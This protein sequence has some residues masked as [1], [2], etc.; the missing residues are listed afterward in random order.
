MFNPKETEG[1]V[2]V[3]LS[4]NSLDA[5]SYVVRVERS[6]VKLENIITEIT[7]NYTGLDPY[8]IEHAVGLVQDQIIKYLK[9]GKSVDIMELGRLYPAAKGTVSRDNPQVADLPSL[10]LR[11][12]PSKKAADA[13]AAV[14]AGSFMVRAPEPEISSVVSLKEDAEEGELCRGRQ[15]RVTG[16]KL[17]VAGSEGGVFFVPQGADGLPCKDEGEWIKAAGS[18]YLPRNYPKTLEF[19]IPEDTQ[20]G[21]PYFV[22]VRTAYSP[23]GR[24]RREAVTGFSRDVVRI[25]R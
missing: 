10:T 22:A 7:S 16:A 2:N 12:K 19:G 25:V 17:K 3:F 4:N 23:S 8:T 14:S 1:N 20:D 6:T 15:V 13:L 11:F 5:R 9:E 18:S 21:V 24:L